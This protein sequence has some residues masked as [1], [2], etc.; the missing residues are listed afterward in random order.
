MYRTMINGTEYNYKFKLNV[1]K[2]FEKVSSK[3]M[4][5]LDESNI[6]DILLF[7]YSIL[8]SNKYTLTYEEFEEELEEDPQTFIK[9]QEIFT[10]YTK[11]LVERSKQLIEKSEIDLKNLTE[12]EKKS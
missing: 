6:N 2:E 5:D 3:K 12:E 10:N 8:K 7:V 4:D 1:Y 11:E 9:V